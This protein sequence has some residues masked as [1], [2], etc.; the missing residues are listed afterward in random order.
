MLALELTY[1]EGSRAG[2]RMCR[3]GITKLMESKEEIVDEPMF[4]EGLQAREVADAL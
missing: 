3:E 4:V 1:I 2:V